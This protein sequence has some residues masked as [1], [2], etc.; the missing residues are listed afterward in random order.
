ML[1]EQSCFFFVLSLSVSQLVS[2]YFTTN[3]STSLNESM[4]LNRIAF[5]C[6]EVPS[7]LSK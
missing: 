2:V 4:L 3:S 1:A 7:T 5:H 6:F